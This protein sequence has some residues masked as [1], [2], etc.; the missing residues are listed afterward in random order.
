[1]TGQSAAIAGLTSCAASATIASKSF[2]ISSPLPETDGDQYYDH[3]LQLRSFAVAAR[4]QPPGICSAFGR[5]PRPMVKSDLMSA[6]CGPL[7]IQIRHTCSPR[8]ARNNA[9]CHSV[10]LEI[11]L[12]LSQHAGAGRK[13]RWCWIEQGLFSNS[14]SAAPTHVRSVLFPAQVSCM[15]E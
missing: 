5:R 7:L 15:D 10:N 4:P 14:A 13:H 8:R 3:I 12:R 2:F 1:M 6:R 11:T 9:L